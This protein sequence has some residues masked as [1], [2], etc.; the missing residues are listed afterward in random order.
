M[1]TE[2]SQRS[3]HRQMNRAKKQSAF[4]SD[5]KSLNKGSSLFLEK[6]TKIGD[7]DNKRA[8]SRQVRDVLQIRKENSFNNRFQDNKVP[9]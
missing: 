5:K 1:T 4:E 6:I 2:E 7:D 3:T 8:K 9:F